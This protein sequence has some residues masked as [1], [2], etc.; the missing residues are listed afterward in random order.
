MKTQHEPHISKALYDEYLNKKKVLK[1][2]KEIKSQWSKK[3]ETIVFDLFS[4]KCVDS[5][6][7][8][9]EGV[10]SKALVNNF[11]TILDSAIVYQKR[12]MELSLIQ[13]EE[14]IKYMQ[15]LLKKEKNK[16]GE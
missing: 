14:E 11:V 16:K 5:S 1:K 9:F 8:Y 4:I 12:E 10:L 3:N 13:C 7:D 2:L 6:I 15:N